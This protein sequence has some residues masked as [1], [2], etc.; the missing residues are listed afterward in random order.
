MTDVL[1][2]VR[3]GHE[4]EIVQHTE[5]ESV[6]RF[7]KGLPKTTLI[8]FGVLEIGTKAQ[9]MKVHRRATCKSYS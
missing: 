4:I 6:K 2:L 8:Y 9:Q 5:K 7:N 3:C 1:D